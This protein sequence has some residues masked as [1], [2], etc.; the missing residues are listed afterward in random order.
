MHINYNCSF[1]SIG[2]GNVSPGCSVWVG[3]LLDYI[4][5]SPAEYV[6]VL[7]VRV[8][9][10]QRMRRFVVKKHQFERLSLSVGCVLSC[11]LSLTLQVVMCKSHRDR[12]TEE[13]VSASVYMRHADLTSF[14]TL[15]IKHSSIAGAIEMHRS[16]KAMGKLNR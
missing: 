13:N 10:L 12:K 7:S 3:Y 2:E 14:E 1:L 6:A 9:N 15:S 4:K 8:R 5:S 11:V 16:V